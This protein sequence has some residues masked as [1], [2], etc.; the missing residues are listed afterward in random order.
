M[1]S[2]VEFT[3][4]LPGQKQY[5]L[6]CELE[7][8]LNKEALKRLAK[9]IDCHHIKTIFRTKPIDS[10]DTGPSL[11]L[12]VDM[13]LVVQGVNCFFDLLEFNDDVVS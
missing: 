3:Y 7:V 4:Q 10:R 13:K 9:A 8:A 1:V 12:C 6:D 2:E 11:K 5:S